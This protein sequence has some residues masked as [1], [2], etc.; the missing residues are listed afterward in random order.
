MESEIVNAGFSKNTKPLSIKKL[1]ENANEKGLE[2]YAT[3]YAEASKFEHSDFSCLDI[4]KQR[5][6]KDN[7]PNQAFILDMDNSDEDLRKKVMT[8]IIISYIESTRKLIEEVTIRQTHLKQL[9]DEK[10]LKEIMIKV[11]LIAED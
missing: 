2:L 8:M 4:Y 11:I 3:F 10:K 7:S 9:Y 5:L 6:S 1:A